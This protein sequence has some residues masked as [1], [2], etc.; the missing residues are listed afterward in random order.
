MLRGKVNKSNG[1]VHTL[2]PQVSGQSLFFF[3]S[4]FALVLLLGLPRLPLIATPLPGSLASHS[5]SVNAA[6]FFEMPA[7]Y[8]VMQ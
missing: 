6:V 2:L 4:F 3:P 8:T 1:M 7:P 5:A